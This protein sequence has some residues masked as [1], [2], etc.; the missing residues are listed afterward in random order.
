VG[1]ARFNRYSVERERKVIMP[2]KIG[3]WN[4]A[5]A[6]VDGLHAHAPSSDFV[7]FVWQRVQLGHRTSEL[8]Q[9]IE[10]LQAMDVRADDV[11]APIEP[12]KKEPKK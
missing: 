9:T 12:P 6:Y 4:D 1:R 11:G 8:W 3:D 10:A 2:E 7:T 5:I